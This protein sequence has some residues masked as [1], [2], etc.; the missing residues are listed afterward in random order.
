MVTSW[1]RAPHTVD[2]MF[3]LYFDYFLF[4]LFLSLVLKAALRFSSLQ[5]LVL[6][7]AYV[8]LAQGGQKP[9]MHDGNIETTKDVTAWFPQ[10]KSH[11]QGK[12]YQERE[13]LMFVIQPV[14]R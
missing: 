12:G 2:H 14:I 4:Q 9:Y 5:F 11:L 8:L 13:E 1:E 10:F 6:V 3:S 7:I